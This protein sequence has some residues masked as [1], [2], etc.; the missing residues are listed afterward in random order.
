MQVAFLIPSTS[1]NR[2]W[3]NIHETYLFKILL[4]SLSKMKCL[5]KFKVFVGYDIDDKI[6][7]KQRIN[8]YENIDI[9]WIGVE[10]FKGNPCGIWNILGEVAM[11][12]GYEYFKVLGDDIQIPEDNW[13]DRFLVNLHLNNKIGFCSGW[14]NNDNI[15]TQFLIHKTHIDIMGFIYP[16]SIHNWFCDDWMY[17]VYPDK[18][19]Y[20]NKEDKLLNC[21]GDPR[22]KPKDDKNLA[23]RLIKRHRPAINR[24]INMNKN[25]N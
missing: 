9:E 3:N 16:P 19:R 25:M 20:W 18:F 10:G 22:Y 12:Q 15:P 8:K 5:S 24:F 23:I 11:N 14:S 2:D 21:G 4:P 13:L 1:N 6:Y 17:G 7:S